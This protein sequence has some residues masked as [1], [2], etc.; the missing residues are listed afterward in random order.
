LLTLYQAGF[1]ARTYQPQEKALELKAKDQDY[2]LNL[3]GLFAKFDHD[4]SLWKTPQYSLNEDLEK[5]SVTWPRWGM[6]RNGVCSVRPIA[7]L[8]TKEK[9]S[10]LWLPTI[11]KNEYKGSSKA[12]YVGSA[13]FRGA[14]MSE[15]LRT[16]ETDPIYLN[17]CFAEIA[18]G[19]PMLWTVLAPLETDKYQSWLRQHGIF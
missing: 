4:M 15:G 18:M 6:M 8:P 10:G 12:R 9:E 17:P 1:H 16:C 3:Q 14:K 13:A 2:G 5:C 7:A 19:W 11:G